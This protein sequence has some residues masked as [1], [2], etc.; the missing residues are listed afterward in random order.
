M[1]HFGCH[2]L[3]QEL[4]FHIRFVIQDS[5]SRRNKPSRVLKGPSWTFLRNWQVILRALRIKP[6]TKEEAN[7]RILDLAPSKAPQ[8]KDLIRLRLLSKMLR[9]KRMIRSRHLH[10]YI[11][12]KLSHMVG[13]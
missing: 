5:S 6:T 12:N 1:V 2:E 8:S 13:V 7:G 4:Y 11:L 3:T 10:T 9:S